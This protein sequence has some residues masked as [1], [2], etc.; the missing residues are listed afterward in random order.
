MKFHLL[1]QAFA[2]VTLLVG[3]KMFVIRELSYKN[4]IIYKILI[5]DT[6]GL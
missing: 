6:N 2:L 3:S 4:I 5:L 1:L